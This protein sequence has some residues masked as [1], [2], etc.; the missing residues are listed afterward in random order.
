MHSQLAGC[1]ALVAFIFFEHSRNEAALELPNGFGVKNIALVHL[2]YE[3][4]QL[5]FHGDLSF[6]L[7]KG[8][9]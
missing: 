1:T 9:R 8:S 7:L 2:L 3:C 4:F 5:I 6:R